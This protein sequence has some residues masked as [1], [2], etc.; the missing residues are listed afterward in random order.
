MH[1]DGDG[2][3]VQRE[4]VRN[5]FGDVGCHDRG[6]RCEAAHFPAGAPAGAVAVSPPLRREA[7][8]WQG[9]V[10]ERPR[11]AIPAELLAGLNDVGKFLEL[12][13]GVREE[14]GAV[15]RVDA[16]G[17]GHGCDHRSA[18]GG[19]V[20]EDTRLALAPRRWIVNCD[21]G[22]S[23]HGFTATTAATT[24]ATA[25]GGVVAGRSP[26]LPGLRMHVPVMVRVRLHPLLALLSRGLH[27]VHRKRHDRLVA[28]ARPGKGDAEE[29]GE[30][31]SEYEPPLVQIRADF[32]ARLATF[33][34][35]QAE[36]HTNQRERDEEHDPHGRH[37]Q[38]PAHAG[39]Q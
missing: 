9:A 16:H 18:H 4:I 17:E 10:V 8:T 35:A 32:D 34:Y 28:H 13:Q 14:V 2:L 31:S 3:R 24:A 25:G 7:R 1:C 21:C 33:P 39:K 19:G 11:G 12:A 23:L 38:H 29:Y 27:E 36:T 22:P 37:R 30:G 26:I 5:R 20:I 15:P 6:H